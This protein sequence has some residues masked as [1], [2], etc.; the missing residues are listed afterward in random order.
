MYNEA[1]KIVQSTGFREDGSFLRVDRALAE[2]L[3][4][5]YQE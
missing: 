2:R 3:L 5:E 4:E 1:L